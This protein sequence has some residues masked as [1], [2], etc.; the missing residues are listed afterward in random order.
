MTDNHKMTLAGWMARYAKSLKFDELPP[1]VIHQS[2]RLLLDALGC[3]I[4]ANEADATKIIH[5]LI[6]TLDSPKESTVLG[7]GLRTSCF[8]ATLV[9]GLMLRYLDYN[10][11]YV[12]PAGKWYAGGHPSESIPV[13]LA[14]GE[15]VHASGQEV[16][17]A[18]VL[19]YE[20][21]ARFCQSITDPPLSKLGWNEETK[22]VY[23]MPLAAG[24]L[25]GLSEKELENAVGMSEIVTTDGRHYREKV[26]FPKG[27][28]RN[29]MSDH[30]LE[31][32]FRSMAAAY[33]GPEQMERAIQTIY[34]VDALA[35]IGDLMKPFIFKKGSSPQ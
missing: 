12:V 3:C 10:D 29:A 13:I 27:D 34:Q 5:G 25:L 33:M 20:L 21:S 16:L 30:D 23:I 4:G 2:K 6:E 31:Q 15:R 9:N 18:I 24:R 22:G 32:K 7:S 19:S 35:D 17:A 26:D 28:P 11:L 8:Y 14:V 1:E